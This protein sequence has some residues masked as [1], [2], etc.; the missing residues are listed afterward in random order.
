M[1]KDPLSIS[2]I[3]QGVRLNLGSVDIEKADILTITA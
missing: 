1:D 2:Y 3:S